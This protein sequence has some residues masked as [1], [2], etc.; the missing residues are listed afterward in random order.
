[1]TLCEAFIG[2]ESHLNL[3]SFLFWARLS[4]GSD[5]RVVTLGSV[6]IL[7]HSGPHIDPYFAILKSMVPIEERMIPAEERR[8]HTTPCIYGWSSHP[9]S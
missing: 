8:Q 5:T 1:V 9:P 2:I 6:D 4:Q 3:W 7:V